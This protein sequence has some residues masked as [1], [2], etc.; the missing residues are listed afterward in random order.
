MAGKTNEGSCP[1]HVALAALVETILGCLGASDLRRCV[2]GTTDLVHHSDR[3]TQYLSMRYSHRLADVGIAL[4]VAA[5]EI[6]TPSP[7]R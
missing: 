2:N 6:P 3:G 4:S 5:A 1:D 7:N